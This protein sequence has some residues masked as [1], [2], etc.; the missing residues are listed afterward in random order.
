MNDNI[1]RSIHPQLFKKMVKLGIEP[2]DEYFL[3]LEL[4]VASGKSVE[5]ALR[6]AAEQVDLL[7]K[8]SRETANVI[9]GS[10]AAVADDANRKSEMLFFGD[11]DRR[12]GLLRM[13][14]ASGQAAL[15]A[16]ANV[17]ESASRM[18]QAAERING[19]MSMVECREVAGYWIKVAL[20]S[21]IISLIFAFVLLLY[22]Y[23]LERVIA[24]R[25]A[26]AI[27]RAYSEAFSAQP[28]PE[29]DSLS[30]AAKYNGQLAAYERGIG[31]MPPQLAL[32]LA[33]A[34]KQ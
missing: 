4:L 31:E 15:T 20:L 14:D 11:G 32:V 26:V 30:G 23:R 8:N 1:I 27:V 16:A 10:L 33:Q 3:L 9:A 5:V 17:R 29:S 19:W 18:E 28:L 12:P 21:T 13:V 22:T 25:N 6:E 2:S 24:T 7:R 34:L